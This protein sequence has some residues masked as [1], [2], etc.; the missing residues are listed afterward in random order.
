MA[1]AQDSLNSGKNTA[2]AIQGSK[3]SSTSQTRISQGKTT[4]P[5]RLTTTDSLKLAVSRDSLQKLN[6]MS[7]SAFNIGQSNTSV[8]APP[9]A[10]TPPAPVVDNVKILQKSDNPFDIVS[11]SSVT[12]ITDSGAIGK[13]EASTNPSIPSLLTPDLYAKNFLFWLFLIVLVLMAL[14]VANARGAIQNAYAAIL[15]DSALRQIYKEPIGWGNLAYLALYVLSW[16][17]I[18]IFTFLLYNKYGI[19]LPYSK[20]TI[21]AFCFLG[22]SGLFLMRHA[23]LYIIANVFPIAKEVR[24]YNFIIMTAGLLMGLSLMPFNIFIA[25]VPIELSQLF[26]YGAFGVIIIAYLVRSLRGLTV[27]TTFLMDNKF[28]FLL[29]LCTVEF[30]PLLVLIKFI[31][32]YY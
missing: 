29:Y 14:V 8:N 9:P 20:F 12:N 16:L 28:H 7:G 3:T 4:R 5:R 13:K 31:M 24:T 1:F 26:V 2:P 32:P 23:V 6:T 19:K 25:Y 11:S 18:A 17:S 22:V 30:A 21:F 10:N 15:S 27:A